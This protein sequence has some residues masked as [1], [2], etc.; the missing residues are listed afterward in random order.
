MYLHSSI[1]PGDRFSIEDLPS[2]GLTIRQLDTDSTST[3]CGKRQ[4]Q[5]LL[6]KSG[7]A[8]C[9]LTPAAQHCAALLA[10]RLQHPRAE[11]ERYPDR[12]SNGTQN[13]RFSAFEGSCPRDQHLLSCFRPW[14]REKG[15]GCQCFL[16]YAPTSLVFPAGTRQLRA[17][18]MS[19]FRTREVLLEVFVHA[20]S[21]LRVAGFDH[22]LVQNSSAF[23]SLSTRCL[24]RPAPEYIESP[25]SEM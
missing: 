20:R 9:Q 5:V 13:E 6:Q 1:F 2:A 16:T 17:R 18:L 23:T 12:Y 25:Y 11:P 19:A 4:H 22:R 21:S 15:T 7:L 3:S 24:R 8:L 10:Q 14:L